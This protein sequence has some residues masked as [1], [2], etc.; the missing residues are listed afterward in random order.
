MEVVVHSQ[1]PDALA[2]NEVV[3][4]RVRASTQ[5]LTRLV[6]RAV[7]RFKDL[8]G[9]KGGLDKQCLIQLST[10]DGG[11]LVVS[12]RGNNWRA[13][14]DMALSRA[15]RTLTRHLKARQFSARQHQARPRRGLDWQHLSPA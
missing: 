9:P 12:S 6:Q 14:L 10:T 13:T 15:S 2:L 8:N 4:A 5:R 1:H 11:V 3:H 7:V